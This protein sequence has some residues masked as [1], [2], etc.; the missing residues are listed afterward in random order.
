MLQVRENGGY[1]FRAYWK[2][3]R[4][5]HVFV[6]LYYAAALAFFASLRSW[7]GFGLALGMVLGTYLRDLSWIGAARRT[8]PFTNKIIDWD[9]VRELAEPEPTADMSN[10][11]AASPKHS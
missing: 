5:R 9:L 8:W 4:R 1:G 2:T 3:S 11:Q 10:P 7:P 6:V